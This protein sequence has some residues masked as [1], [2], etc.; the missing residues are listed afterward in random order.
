M[1]Y[2]F[3]T[4]AAITLQLAIGLPHAAAETVEYSFT[5]IE[6]PGA[7]GTMVHGINN[8]GVIVGAYSLAEKN[9]GFMLDGAEFTTI[10]FP[11]AAGTNAH[12]INDQGQIVGIFGREDDPLES[13]G[14]VFDGANYEVTSNFPGASSTNPLGINNA[15]RIVGGYSE[16][17]DHDRGF[18]LDGASFTSVEYPGAGSTRVA[19]VNNLGSVVGTFSDAGI[20]LMR[21][22]GFVFDGVSF[23]VIDISDARFTVPLDINDQGVIVGWFVHDVEEPDGGAHGFVRSGDGLFTIDVPGSSATFIRGINNGGYIVGTFIDL[24]FESH[25]F[26]GTPVPEPSS[27]CLLLLACLVAVCPRRLSRSQVNRRNLRR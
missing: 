24:N 15:G 2:V 26:L 19:G 20:I 5:T 25:S 4:M 21:S 6:F 10:D 11:N 18:T 7:E 1:K 3:V 16:M 14:F 8:A 13:Q 27:L 22:E 17:P 9:H 12:D 23:E